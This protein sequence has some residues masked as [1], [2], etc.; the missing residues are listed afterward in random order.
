M[1]NTLLTTDIEITEFLIK[2]I[3]NPTLIFDYFKHSPC[4]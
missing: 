2:E 4:S 1:N 3:Q